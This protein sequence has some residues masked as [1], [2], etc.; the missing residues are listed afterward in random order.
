MGELDGK[1]DVPAPYLAESDRRDGFGAARVHHWKG[2]E[3]R[4]VLPI[5]TFA[6][7]QGCCPVVRERA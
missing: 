6:A 4:T 5:C 3:V 7:Q 2:S 1:G